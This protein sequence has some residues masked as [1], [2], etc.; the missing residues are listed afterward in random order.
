MFT[1]TANNDIFRRRR[2]LERQV[3]DRKFAGSIPVLVI[4]ANYLTGTKYLTTRVGTPLK[5]IFHSVIPFP[6]TEATALAIPCKFG[7]LKTCGLGMRH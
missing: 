1:K 6:L 4:N 7:Q 2:W 3:S 5:V